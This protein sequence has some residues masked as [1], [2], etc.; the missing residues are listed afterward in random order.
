VSLAYSVIST[1]SVPSQPTMSLEDED[2]THGLRNRTGDW[3]HGQPNRDSPGPFRGRAGARSSSGGVMRRS[4]R[5]PCG[6]RSPVAPRT[7]VPITWRTA[8]GSRPT[9]WPAKRCGRCGDSGELRRPGHPKQP[10]HHRQRTKVRR[11]HAVLAAGD[12][13]V[14]MG[15]QRLASGGVLPSPVP[16][17]RCAGASGAGSHD[18]P[19][20][21]SPHAKAV[22]LPELRTTAHLAR[23]RTPRCHVGRIAQR[24]CVQRAAGVVTMR[25]PVT[26]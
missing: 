12:V 9:S 20:G 14:A 8:S 7:T 23:R 18:A 1:H 13:P 2:P 17:C 24:W 25:R 10:S 3:T 4:A 22:N 19:T 15:A 5:R 26:P 21:G 6:R 16:A 11:G